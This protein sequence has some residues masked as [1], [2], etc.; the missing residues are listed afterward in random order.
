MK[1]LVNIFI[2]FVIPISLASE[3]TLAF[4]LFISF[5]LWC[6]WQIHL[7]HF[8][9]HTSSKG[10]FYL[11][12]F[13]NRGKQFNS[14][15]IIAHD[16]YKNSEDRF[17]WEIVSDY[18]YKSEF[19]MILFPISARIILNE[20]R[21]DRYLK[22]KYTIDKNDNIIWHFTKMSPSEKLLSDV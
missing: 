7:S 2:W 22:V 13:Y 14:L 12:D 3:I 11:T 19:D 6:L 9:D 18:P 20:L 10:L 4:S 17:E 21:K 15:Y 1:R 16:V 8:I 5:A